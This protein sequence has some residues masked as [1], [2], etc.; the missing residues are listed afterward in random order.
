MD[1]T[2]NSE[3]K[4]KTLKTLAGRQRCGATVTLM[5]DSGDAKW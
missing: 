3:N 5:H 1:K 2:Q 4:H